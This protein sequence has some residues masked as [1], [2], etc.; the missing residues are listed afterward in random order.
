MVKRSRQEVFEPSNDDDDDDEFDVVDTDAGE[1][2]R[3]ERDDDDNDGKPL[4]KRPPGRGR[5]P[6]DDDVR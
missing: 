6:H 3:D 1:D 4:E 5:R 2:E